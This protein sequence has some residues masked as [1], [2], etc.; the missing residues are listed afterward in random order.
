MYCPCFYVDE[1]TD[2]VD[3]VNHVTELCEIT[4]SVSDMSCPRCPITV[5]RALQ[6]VEGVDEVAVSLEEKQAIVQFDPAE[7]N[8][9]ELIAA[10][11]AAGFPSRRKE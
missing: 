3:T 8:A 6:G 9:A 2:Y 5:R 4:L 7:T 1:D 10:T 11:T